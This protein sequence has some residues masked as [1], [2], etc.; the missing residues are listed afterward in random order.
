MLQR[1]PTIVAAC[2]ALSVVLFC[3]AAPGLAAEKK[4]AD[5]RKIIGTVYPDSQSKA[6]RYTR[7]AS[8]VYQNGRRIPAKSPESFAVMD[9]RSGYAKDSQTAYWLGTPIPEAD[10]ATFSPL[11]LTA[12]FLPNPASRQGLEDILAHLAWD[13]SRLYHDG[14]V[15]HSFQYPLEK[16]YPPQEA[17]PIRSALLFARDSAGVIA[18][19]A[20]P[21]VRYLANVI[22]LFDASRTGAATAEGFQVL[23]ELAPDAIVS[24]NVDALFYNTQAVPGVAPGKA[25]VFVFDDKKGVVTEN[26]VVLAGYPRLYALNRTDGQKAAVGEKGFSSWEENAEDRQPV[27]RAFD[28]RF[29]VTFG[30]Q[31]LLKERANPGADW[32]ISQ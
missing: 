28:G 3:A 5:G 17:P 2:C 24:I 6:V 21:G 14:K 20:S 7:D 10:P 30:K 31:I 15:I 18:I 11:F 27:I 19:K 32:V 9:K 12:G 13:K 1:I 23:G 25:R 4:P 22:R 16:L 29:D 8:G 26:A